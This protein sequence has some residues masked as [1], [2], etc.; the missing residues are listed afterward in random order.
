MAI[1]YMTV[2]LKYLFLRESKKNLNFNFS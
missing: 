2:K 1:E